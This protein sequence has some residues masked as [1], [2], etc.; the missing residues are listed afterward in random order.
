[1]VETAGA[2]ESFGDRIQDGEILEASAHVS[3]GA[4]LPTHIADG[5]FSQTSSFKGHS[6][7]PDLRIDESSILQHE[8]DLNSSNLRAPLGRPQSVAE[9][10]LAI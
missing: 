9:R 10:R 5:G 7:Q 3:R 2:S 4:A 1:M 8:P 6:P